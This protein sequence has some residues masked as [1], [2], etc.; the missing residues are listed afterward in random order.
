MVHFKIILLKVYFKCEELEGKHSA[1]WKVLSLGQLSTVSRSL[2]H[3]WQGHSIN[4]LL[5]E[6]G[7]ILHLECLRQCASVLSYA[8]RLCS[9]SI[10]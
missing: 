8:A 3:S 5:T 6:A 4:P 7:D 9:D 2:L 1:I 10:C